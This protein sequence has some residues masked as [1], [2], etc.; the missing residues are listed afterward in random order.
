MLFRF[1]HM[2]NIR[3]SESNHD[4]PPAGLTITGS[5]TDTAED[6]PSLPGIVSAL[7]W[8]WSHLAVPL[9]SS[10]GPRLFCQVFFSTPA[11]SHRFSITDGLQ[12]DR[13]WVFCVINVSLLFFLLL[14]AYLL[15]SI[16]WCSFCLFGGFLKRFD[17]FTFCFFAVKTVPL[18]IPERDSSCSKLTVRTWVSRWSVFLLVLWEATLPSWSISFLLSWLTWYFPALFFV[19]WRTSAAVFWRIFWR[20]QHCCFN[21]LTRTLDDLTYPSLRFTCLQPGSGCYWLTASC[22]K[23]CDL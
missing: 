11:N 10:A 15:K 4:T 16:V 14:A 1:G 6:L 8:P 21:S 12:E 19:F 17:H 23:T 7:L 3:S 13:C 20:S 2:S 18:S 22:R 5:S 9:Q